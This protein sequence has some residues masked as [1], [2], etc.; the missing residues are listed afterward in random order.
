MRDVAEAAGVSL[1]TVSRVFNDEPGV[2]P[3]VADRVRE[4]M[5]RVGYQRDARAGSFRHRTTQTIGVVLVDGANPFF[6]AVNR[7][8]EDVARDHGHL[9]L[10]GSGDADPIREAALT[11]ALISQRVDG[12]ILAPTAEPDSMLRDEAA[13]GLPVVFVDHLPGG[14]LFGD[15][16]LTDHRAG[17]ELAVRHL[18]GHGHHRVA[19]LGDAAR[20]YS[21][22]E[23]LAGHAAALGE[24]GIEVDP[25]LVVTEIASTEQAAVETRRL[26]ESDRPPTALFT[27]MNLATIG[28][29]GALHELGRQHEVALVAFD[30]VDFSTVVEP[31]L[32]VVPQ[33]ATG[34]GRLAADRLFRRLAGERGAPEVAR[35][36]VSLLPR[37]S[38]EIERT[39]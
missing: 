28:A 9:V 11:R 33:D 15:A 14:T 6:A 10:S 17:A 22:Q 16:V 7:G 19:F 34:L 20:L 3:E 24:A 39:G 29:V 38:G 21:T 32:T 26:L 12:L 31:A 36:A 30:D 8:V 13:R 37:G 35:L 23:R 27:A 1:K 18:V 2:R 25:A 4:E 5:A